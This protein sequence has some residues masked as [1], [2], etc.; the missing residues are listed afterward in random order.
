MENIESIKKDAMWCL[1]CKTKPCSEKGCPMQTNIPEFI[2]E[3]KKDNIESAYNILYN[4]NIFSH[5]CSIVCPQEQQCEGSCIRGI[6]Q[7]ATNIGKLEKF[8]N[9]WALENLVKPEIKTKSKNGKK[10]AIVGSGPAGLECAFELAKEGFD[11]TIFEKDEMPG[12]ILLYGIPDFRL[13][14]KIVNQIVKTLRELGV[15]FETKKELGKDITVQGLSKEYDAVFLGIGATVSSTYKLSDEET[16][17]VFESD[18][19]L[20]EY[21]E[22]RKINN[23]GTAIVIGGGNVAMDSARAAIRM[24]AENVKILYRRDRA[25][26]PAR[27]I[28]LDE[29]IEDGVEFKELTRVISL[30]KEN[31]ENVSVNCIQTEIV[32]GKAVD[33]NGKEFI[34]KA[35]SVIFAI[36]LKPNKKLIEVEGITLDDWGYIQIDED[37]KTNLSNVYAG[38]DCTE[39]K[40]TVCRALAAGK[41]AALGIIKNV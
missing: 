1:N 28:E 40:S 29:A 12:G 23:L 24:G 34:E 21:N 25:H 36:G 15:K 26:M 8:V 17:N 37:G 18:Y 22:G 19:F 3:I 31:G 16:K 33:V 35:N 39:S 7:T 14:K 6:N 10:I 41:K 5:I 32:D 4:N 13:N 27:E 9:E 20:K 2:E 38:G 30:N 11:I